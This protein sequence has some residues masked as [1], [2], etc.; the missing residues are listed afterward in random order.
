MCEADEPGRKT[1]SVVRSNAAIVPAIIQPNV[2]CV[3]VTPLGLP[4]LPDVK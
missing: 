4:V 2:S 1:S 3:W